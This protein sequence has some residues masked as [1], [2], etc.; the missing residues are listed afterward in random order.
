MKRIGVLGYGGRISGV[1]NRVVKEAK[2]KVSV[3]A[4]YD[5]SK[6]AHARA[7]K[8]YPGIRACKS[9]KE[10]VGIKELDWIFIGSFN[11][12]HRDH[13]IAA[14]NAGKHVFCEKPLA[15]TKKHCLD[16][17]KA[18]RAHPGKQFAIGFV[19]RYSEFYRTM[20]KWIDEG[21]LGTLISMEFNETLAPQHGAAMHGN[22]RRRTDL[23]GPMIVEKCCH[24]MDIMLWMTG[25]RPSRVAS[26]GGLNFFKP[27][28][29]HFN[30]QYPVAKEGYKFYDRGLATGRYVG[31]ENNISPFSND[32]DTI[33]N[34]VAIMELENGSRV[35]FHYC[36]HSAQLERRFY[37]C[38]TKGTIRG[39]VLTGTLEYTPVGWD[40]KTETVRPIEGNDHGNAEE[41]MTTDIINCML[42][43]KPMPTTLE[44]GLM[45]SFTSL[46][47]DEARTKGKIVDMQSYWKLIRK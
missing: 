8:E 37:M 12:L 3:D 11:A 31:R 25:T 34:Q 2:G 5:P 27:K 46:G 45:A 13:A 26:F 4:F 7:A 22:W 14:I 28:N 23:S 9:V 21:R 47:V 33:D 18:R 15:T 39:N 43:G 29:A 32:K 16:I 44:D 35:S 24:D 41:P 42:R 19:L 20:K 36:M 10:L 1:I 17:L 38:G 40:P 30:D 6:T